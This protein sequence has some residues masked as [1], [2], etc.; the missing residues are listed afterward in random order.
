M[1]CRR[2][3][4][5]A[6]AARPTGRA[7]TAAACTCMWTWMRRRCESSCKSGRTA[8]LLASRP[9]ASASCHSAPRLSVHGCRWDGGL[10]QCQCRRHRV[11][12]FHTA[13]R[14]AIAF[15]AKVWSLV[16]HTCGTHS[17]ESTHWFLFFFCF[18][19]VE[20]QPDRALQVGAPDRRRHRG[21]VKA[22]APRRRA[23][24]RPAEP[25]ARHR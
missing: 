10:P 6:P 15:N 14:S 9:Q 3:N 1:L 25:G 16:M 2:F 5:R 13:Q 18:F 19:C 22:A 7:A 17:H 11:H 12:I 4:V 8:T 21:A 20:N 24:P 23:P